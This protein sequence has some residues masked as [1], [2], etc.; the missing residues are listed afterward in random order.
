MKSKKIL[1]CLTMGFLVPIFSFNIVLAASSENFSNSNDRLIG[2][3]TDGQSENFKAE[4]TLSFPQ[5]DSQ[6]AN[7]KVQARLADNIVV[8]PAP[9]P[10][11]SPG[12][13]AVILPQE[14]RLLPIFKEITD[15][16]AVISWISPELSTSKI[17]Y[18]VNP[19][20]LNKSLEDLSYK[21]DHSLRLK[22]LLPKTVYHIR[23]ESRTADDRIIKSDISSF[24]TKEDFYPPNNVLNFAALSGEGFA[25]LRWKNPDNPDF[26][27]VLIRRSRDIYPVNPGDG[28][29]VYKGKTE[30]YVDLNLENGARY[31]Y[32]IFSYDDKNNYSSGSIANAIPKEKPIPS[33]GKLPEKIPEISG[34][35]EIF[36]SPQAT[37]TLPEVPKKDK[38]DL[39]DIYFIIQTNEGVLKLATDSINQGLVKI[40]K[41]TPLAVS[42]PKQSFK[43]PPELIVFSIDN[44]AYL[45]KGNEKSYD[46]SLQLPNKKGDFNFEILFKWKKGAI[47]R[48]SSKINIDPSGYVFQNVNGQELR[49]ADAKVMLYQLNTET[50]GFELWPGFSFNQ[51]NPIMTDESGEFAFYVSPGKY[52]I[53]VTKGGQTAKTEVFEIKDSPLINK[54]IELKGEDAAFTAGKFEIKNIFGNVIDNRLVVIMLGAS[55]MLTVV[56]IFLILR[57]KK[58]FKL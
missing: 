7:Y 4:S 53:E 23:L 38:L 13:G 33:I 30:L 57:R 21:T 40:V 5:P 14:N 3:S 8:E 50:D 16:T 32:T 29:F 54:K 35:V 52:Y 55:A 34:P 41:N 58:K 27:G 47:Q 25:T 6:S 51:I 39:S 43:E 45:F 11:A 10:P 44:S 22:N 24:T 19:N 17:Y 49:I 42:I 26:A 36:P 28:E 48:L 56:L 15:T 20:A 31:Y 9:A 12:G 2:G 18:G 37:G 46:L 1:F